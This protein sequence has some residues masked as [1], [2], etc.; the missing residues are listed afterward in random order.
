MSS[1]LILRLRQKNLDKDLQAK[2]AASAIFVLK[3]FIEQNK[4]LARSTSQQ[5]IPS[6]FIQQTTGDYYRKRSSLHDS[7]PGLQFA[8]KKGLG[9]NQ[10]LND[11]VE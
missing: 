1:T 3:R 6:T 5:F 11:E 4:Y 7:I 2:N 10:S 9:S 8:S